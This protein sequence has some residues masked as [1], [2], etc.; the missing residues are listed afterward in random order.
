[1]ADTLRAGLRKT[2]FVARLGGDE[3][4]LLLPETGD[5]SAQL[6]I[7]K[8]QKKLLEAMATSGYPVTFSIGAVT[9][10]RPPETIDEVISQ[11]D[12]LMYAVK[13]AGKNGVQHKS[14]G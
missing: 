6:A 5:G 12:E 9:F 8:V 3:F 4:A 1:V 13:Q 2:D 7:R 14:V 11:A 10:A